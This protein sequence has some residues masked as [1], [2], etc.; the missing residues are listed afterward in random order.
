MGMPGLDMPP[1]P[2]PDVQSQQGNPPTPQ[3]G[4]GALAARRPAGAGPAPGAP[5]PHGAVTTQVETIKKVLANMA[6]TEPLMAPFAARATAILDSGLAAVRSA[7][8]SPEGNQGEI[9]APPVEGGSPPPPGAGIG[10]G[11]PLA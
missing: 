7:P 6:K 9:G 2:D 5:D 10:Q 4:L 11:P 3:P 1:R 8:T